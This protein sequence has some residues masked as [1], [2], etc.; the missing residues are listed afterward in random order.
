[1]K[2]FTCLAAILTVAAMGALAVA[3]DQVSAESEPWFD[4]QTCTCCK[5]L[6]ENMDM[7]SQIDWENHLI[8]NGGMTTAAVPEE[9]KERWD[10]VCKV[11][12][13]SMIKAAAEGMEVPLCNFCKSYDKLMKA[14]AKV[15]EVKTG[16]GSVTLITSDKPEVIKMI[17]QHIKRTQEESKKVEHMLNEQ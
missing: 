2:R 16:F 6:G 9:Y 17:H 8:E 7:L 1:M 13:E 14:G 3:A 11:M 5:H 10:A 12:E 15:E 4:M